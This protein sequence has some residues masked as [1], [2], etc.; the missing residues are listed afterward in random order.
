MGGCRIGWFQGA[1]KQGKVF[2]GDDF[3]HVRRR[4]VNGWLDEFGKR[5]PKTNGVTSMTFDKSTSYMD[6]SFFPEVVEYAKAHLPNA[7]IV[8]T[9]CNPAERLYSEFHSLL[10]DPYQGYKNLYWENEVE[11]PTDFGAFV[12]YFLDEK[13]CKE[14][15][16]FCN[17]N[18]KQYLK[19]GDFLHNLRPWYDTYGRENVL[20]VNM[21]D[22]PSEI[23]KS[24]LQHVGHDIL[25]ESEYPWN[26]VAEPF[27]SNVNK[28]YEGRASSYQYFD[29]EIKWLEQYYAPQNEELAMYLDIDWPRKWNCRVNSD[30]HRFSW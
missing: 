29:N 9:L 8:A 26:E 12:N 19:Q 1:L 17:T 16:G 2:D 7:K 11:P 3:T 22:H 13:V 5:L 30:C 28:K 6:I 23:V 15:E 18:R 4:M 21:E 10:A 20:V 27:A 14:K 24:L 25:P